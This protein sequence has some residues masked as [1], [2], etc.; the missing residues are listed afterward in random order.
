MATQPRVAIDSEDLACQISAKMPRRL[1]GIAHAL[2]L[3]IQIRHVVFVLL[4]ELRDV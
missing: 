3:E 4:V 2:N 1:P